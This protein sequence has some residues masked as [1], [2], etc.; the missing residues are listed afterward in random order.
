MTDSEKVIAS[1]RLNKEHRLD[2]LNAVMKQW[3]VAN[4][5]PYSNPMRALVAAL[6]K[7]TGRDNLP[8]NKAVGK[9]YKAA[10]YLNKLFSTIP[11]EFKSALRL[12]S[13][14]P[15]SLRI[16]D[17]TGAK[18]AELLM[19]MPV[20]LAKEW[21]IPFTQTNTQVYAGADN[22][23]HVWLNS[24]EDYG[25]VNNSESR[26]YFN[27]EFAVFPLSDSERTIV[28]QNDTK[29]WRDYCSKNRKNRLWENTRDL[30]RAETAD[31][32][33]QFKST[34]QIR[35]VW[36]EMLDYLPAHIVDPGLVIKLPALTNS[37]LNERLGI[38]K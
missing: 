35:Q 23:T 36:P 2:A 4:A 32:L 21:S 31:Y 15:L 3:E 19:H 26:S 28:L 13:V 7:R 14:G 27:G 24:M 12:N 37:R 29:L 11:T 38:S 1:V 25:V 16:Q 8:V 20:E 17:P 5:K 30:M 33:E 9:V 34:A 6:T 10:M 18:V 22:N